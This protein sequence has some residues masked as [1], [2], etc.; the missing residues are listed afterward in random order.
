MLLGIVRI[1]ELLF[2]VATQSN[3]KILERP[4]N[5]DHAIMYLHRD[6]LY[7]Y[8]FSNHTEVTLFKESR[9]FREISCKIWPLEA[10]RTLIGPRSLWNLATRPLAKQ[11][12]PTLRSTHLPSLYVF[13][14]NHQSYGNLNII[15]GVLIF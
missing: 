12:D 3:G 4:T 10:C 5:G 14:N 6:G 15:Y 8:T 9:G 13:Y 7:M 1:F 2:K 11:T